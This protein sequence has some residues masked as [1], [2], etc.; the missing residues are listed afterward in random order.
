MRLVSILINIVI[1]LIRMGR[2]TTKNIVTIYSNRNYMI[3]IVYSMDSTGVKSLTRLGSALK[4]HLVKPDMAGKILIF[5]QT[6]FELD[7]VSGLLISTMLKE[8]ISTTLIHLC[9]R[10]GKQKLEKHL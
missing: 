8:K 3:V 9:A 2:Y 10:W 4:A 7:L 1:R 6:W 5:A